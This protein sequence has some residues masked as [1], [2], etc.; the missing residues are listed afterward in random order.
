MFCEQCGAEIPKGTQFCGT[1][2]HKI[3]YGH[4]SSFGDV[5]SASSGRLLK[6]VG[7]EE[8]KRFSLGELLSDVFKRHTLAE[9]EEHFLVGTSKTTPPVSKIK[10]EWPKPWMFLRCF[11]TSVIL[12]VLFSFAQ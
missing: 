5:F 10:C 1:C 4:S 2:G 3:V 9:R 6:V 7:V 11:A 12:Y 8:V